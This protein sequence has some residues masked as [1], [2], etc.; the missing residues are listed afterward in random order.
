M[1]T[2]ART[3]SPEAQAALKFARMLELALSTAGFCTD[4]QTVYAPVLTSG[5]WPTA[6]FTVSTEGG[7]F[8]VGVERVGEETER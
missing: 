3:V 2:P 7:T 6:E 5:V 1:S 4:R 8:R